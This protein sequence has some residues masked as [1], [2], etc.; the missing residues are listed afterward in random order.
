L[1]EEKTKDGKTVYKYIKNG[2]N[3]EETKKTEEGE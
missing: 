2:N 1:K 3:S